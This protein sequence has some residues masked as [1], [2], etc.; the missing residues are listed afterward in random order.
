[1]P[2]G[3]SV[4]SRPHVPETE[5]TSAKDDLIREFLKILKVTFKMATIYRLEH[6]SFVGTVSDFLAK[7]DALF[8]FLNPLTIGFTPHS[9]FI[10]N[11]FW[12]NDKTCLHLAQL[13]HFRK[14]K[15]LE[16]R[17][18]ITLDEL[19][20][21][22]SKITLPV[23]DFI[24][25]GGAGNILRKER[26]A[27]I[28]VEE[29]DYAQLL[30]GEGEEIKDIWP[31]LL[32][33][34]V[35]EDDPRKL[36][37]MAESL[38][39]IAGKFNTEDLIQNEEL[40]KSFVKFFRYLKETAD[41]KH[42]L[43]AKS[44]L[45]SVLAG[46]KMPV[47]AKFENLKLL[48][49]DMTEEDL[50]SALWEEIIANDKFDS[51]SFSVFS[52]II[53]KE[54]HKKVSTSLR[55]LFHS[56]EPRNRRPEVERKLRLLLSGT[57]GQMLSDIYRQTLSNLLSEIS[58]E[59]KMTLDHTLLQRNYR[60]L[61]LNL[62]AK[63]APEGE[64]GKRLERITEEWDK[65]AGEGDLDFLQRL[66]EVLDKQEPVLAG[67][68]AFQKVKSALAQHVESRILQ[69]ESG[70][71]LDYFI[72][73]LPER[74]FD[75][76]VYL[77]KIFTEKTV[78]PTLLRAYFGFF[79]GQL[80]EFFAR[81]KSKSSDSR[82]LARI[83]NSLKAIDSL[84]SLTCLKNIYSLGDKTVRLQAVEAMRSLSEIDEPFLFVVLEEKEIG[85]KSEALVLLTRHERAKHV[86]LAKLLNLQS[87]Y[88]TRNRKLIKH[89]RLVEERGLRDAARFLESL[90]LRGNFWNRKVRQEAHRVL[91]KW[92]GA[93]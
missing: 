69:G 86:A 16:I 26:I 6:P 81:L 63:D 82:L 67:E 41:E 57:S 21:F 29:L 32:M 52:R 15:K 7:L 56:D 8:S 17:Q 76:T 9:V 13:F 70:P 11:R 10:D 5:P 80:P 68:A 44:L 62:L 77:D 12:E 22:A 28:T 65:I 91:E 31:Y 46:K 38:E 51:L 48:I 20:K 34:A 25:E 79:P 58:F 27:H 24:K 60:Y 66:L 71:A 59:K 39:K 88:G 47:E 85:L 4:E 83:I 84:L 43:C 55:D 93:C 92:A 42:R 74:A 54:R 40:Q 45:K 49:S 2:I 1:M 18:G 87:P 90:S 72:D 37:Q 78:T 23:R 50:A 73:H 30:R 75:R 14:I 89:I 36:D 33:E 53:S 19:T 61:L 35:E 64:A 3:Y